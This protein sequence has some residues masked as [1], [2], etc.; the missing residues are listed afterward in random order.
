MPTSAACPAA[1]GT[2]TPTTIAID[3]NDI[4]ATNVN[5][6]T[7][8]GFGVLSANGT[9]EVLMDYKSEHPDKYVEML[10]VL[11][12]GTNPIMTQV[13][14]EMGNDRNNSTGPDAATMRTANEAANIKRDPSFQL[15]ADAKK[16][17]PSL[18]VSILRWNS[19]A[20]ANTTDKIYTWYKNTILTAY[21]EYGTMV[22]YVN[23]G[24]NERAAD[25]TWTKTYASRVKSDTT[26][27][28]DATEQALYNAIKIIISDEADLGTFGDD[29]TSDTALR[30]AVSVAGYHYNTDDDASGNFKKLAEQYDKEVWNSEAQATFGNSAFR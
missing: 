11:F 22:D 25:L 26:G 18:K 14:I 30:S 9:S 6:L 29:M 24:L 1:A 2:G 4:K 15:A 12:G 7:F 17:Q 21:R 28:N 16:F 8:K 3:G 5:G 23:P 10:K 13:K 27:F 20:W 19:P